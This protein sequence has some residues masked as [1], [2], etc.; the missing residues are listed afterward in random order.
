MPK[1]IPPPPPQAS[2]D[3]TGR[4]VRLARWLY[5]LVIGAFLLLAAGYSPQGFPVDYGREASLSWTLWKLEGLD[6]DTLRAE[7]DGRI[8]WL[9]GASVVRESFDEDVIN[10][11]LPEGG[12]RVVK[13]GFDRGASGLAYGMARRLPLQPGDLVVHNVS[14]NNFRRD[15]IAFVELPHW[16]LTTLYTPGEF[17]A[18]D[19]LSVQDKIEGSV[20]YAPRRF[21]SNH[22]EH[23]EGLFLWARSPLSGAPE[24]RGQS[25]HLRFHTGETRKGFHKWRVSERARRQRVHSL[26]R[27]DASPE[28]F[29][30]RG[31]TL[32]RERCEVRGAEL[33]LIT[34]PPS[35][36]MSE[37]L[38]E[39][40]VEPL[41][42]EL[43]AEA[44]IEA[45]PKPPEDDYHDF[46]HP[47]FRGRAML[48]EHMVEWLDGR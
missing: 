28:Q 5:A 39:P 25:V 32:L 35:D 13:I 45:W 21:W 29:N 48:S 16:W 6:V 23:Q 37:L 10:A 38:V 17:W 19:E 12:P 15:W 8:V 18:I 1:P 36:A 31:L 26:E 30:A 42:T 34:I 9:L 41:W 14:A 33:L 4:A 2:E 44:G 3:E 40:G 11:A 47:N 20:N 46:I 27:W 24:A 43:M 22:D 7:G